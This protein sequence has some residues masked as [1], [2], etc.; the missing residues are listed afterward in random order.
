VE[1][2]SGQSYGDFLRERIFVPLGMADTGYFDQTSIV[3]NRA[4]G[5]VPS[6]GPLGLENAPAQNPSSLLGSGCLCSTARDLQK[7]AQAVRSERLFKRTALKYPFGWGARNQ[8]GHRYIEQSGIGTGFTS[9]LIVFLDEPVD[10]V[11]LSNIQS[12]F[13][14]RQEK[15]LTAIAFGAVADKPVPAPKGAAISGRL[16]RSCVGLFQGPGDFRLRIV[17]DGGHLY[18]KFDDGPARAFLLPVSENEL[19]MRT[20]FARIHLT[21]DDRGRASELSIAWGSGGQP[22]KFTRIAQA[23]RGG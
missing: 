16:L 19:F 22:M 8:Y 10:V 7:W 12:G 18:A 5:Y 2:V 23:T 15:D 11:C 20:E 3:P 14:S 9:H 4:C 21:R 6:P 13:F 1:K 17:E